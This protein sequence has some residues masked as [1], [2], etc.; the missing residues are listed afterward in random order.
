MKLQR[1]LTHTIGRRL[2]LGTITESSAEIYRQAANRLPKSLLNQLTKDIKRR[3]V[4]DAMI[5]MHKRGFAPKT[6]RHTLGVLASIL[7][8]AVDNGVIPANPALRI[9]TPKAAPKTN[10]NVSAADLKKVL[11]VAKDHPYGWLFR[12]AL[13]SGLRRGELVALDWSDIDLVAGTVKVSKNVVR[14]SKSERIT[15]PKTNSSYRTVTLPASVIQEA[16]LRQRRPDQSVFE[17][18]TG[19]RMGLASAS[20]GIKSI[21]KEAELWGQTLHSLRHTHASQLVS[22]GLPLPAIAERMGHSDVKTTLGIYSHS[23]KGEDARAATA[24]ETAVS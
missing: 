2:S 17:N 24:I 9:K 10:R 7:N 16:K 22:S 23:S 3:D 12:F 18:S 14:V 20:M 15:T 21:L 13:G 8:D 1:Y 11:G 6:L 5:D 4:E 19:G